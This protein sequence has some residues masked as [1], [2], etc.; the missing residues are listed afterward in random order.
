MKKQFQI[1]ATAVITVAIV[2]CSKQGV[3]APGAQQNPT[4]EISTSSSSSRTVPDPLTV[5]LDGWYTFNSNLKDV[6]KH[7]SDG[8]ATTRGVIYTNDRNNISHNAIKFDGSYGVRFL[9]I[10]QQPHASI[11]AW[12]RIDNLNYGPNRPII[13]PKYGGNG[14]GLSKVGAEVYGSAQSLSFG[15]LGVS[16]GIV[17]N[18][19]H[20]LVVTFDDL[21][22]RMY[23]DG[24]LVNSILCGGTYPLTLQEFFMGYNPN[25][26]WFQGAIDDLRFYSRTL[27]ATDVQ[28]LYNL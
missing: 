8:I 9:N 2:S 14:L 27:S 25:T 21:Y 19:W 22:L 6:T 18:A 1:L 20:H 4:E 16:G 12:V 5:N 17:N 26:E 28:K 24:V 23:K 15:S 3:E 11:A 13:M 10:P 7:L